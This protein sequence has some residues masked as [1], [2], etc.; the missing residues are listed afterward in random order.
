MQEFLQWLEVLREQ[1]IQ[2]TQV[3]LPEPHASL[4]SGI[5]LGEKGDLSSEFKKAL[6]ATG[7]IHVVV[8]SGYNIS[9]ICGW[10]SGMTRIFS[11]KFKFEPQDC[12]KCS[13][14]HRLRYDYGM[15]LPRI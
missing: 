2:N 11:K 4:L 13:G 7:T 8:V 5:V 12:C 3:L 9:L 6:I 15:E 14:C 1:L 10:L